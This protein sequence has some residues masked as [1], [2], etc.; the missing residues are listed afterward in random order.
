MSV[1]VAAVGFLV[2]Q[3]RGL[4]A[5]PLLLLGSVEISHVMSE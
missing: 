5:L 4:T 2:A 3:R 1:G